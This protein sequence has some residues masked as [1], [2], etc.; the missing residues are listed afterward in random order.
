VLREIEGMDTA[1]TALALDVSE[2]VVKTKCHVLEA[3]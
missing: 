3:R 2:A 1:D